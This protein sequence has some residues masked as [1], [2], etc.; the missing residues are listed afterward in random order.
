MEKL[1]KDDPDFY[2]KISQMRKIKSGG[3][4]FLD[5][6]VARAAQAKGVENKLRKAAK[7][8]KREAA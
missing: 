4:T 5:K 3:K 6:E 2:S 1:T 7:R 8:A